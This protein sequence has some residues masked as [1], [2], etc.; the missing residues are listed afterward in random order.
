MILLIDLILTFVRLSHSVPIKQQLS[1]TSFLLLLHLQ[2]K[3]FSKHSQKS[4]KSKTNK[5][6]KTSK[7]SIRLEC[8]NIPW[9]RNFLNVSNTLIVDE[10]SP[11]I[12]RMKNF[13]FVSRFLLWWPLNS[14][15]LENNS[16]LRN[17]ISKLW[18]PEI[19]DSYLKIKRVHVQK[20]EGENAGG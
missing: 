17:L 3:A 10:N 4:Q 14:D 8:K 7:R 19:R 18:P 11:D 12:P 16:K 6:H 15:N 5:T 1:L 13:H 9:K 2:R 20:Q